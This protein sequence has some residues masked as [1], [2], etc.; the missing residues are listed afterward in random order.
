MRVCVGYIDSLVVQGAVEEGEV[1][2]D[3]V[4]VVHPNRQ[5]HDDVVCKKKTR[6]HREACHDGSTR[7]V[8]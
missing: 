8:N 2:R 4:A 5:V 6:K 1:P 3:E 7:I